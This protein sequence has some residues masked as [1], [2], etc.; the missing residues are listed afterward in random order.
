MKKVSLV[1]IILMASF[2]SFAQQK[3][4]GTKT[5]GQW[6]FEK[7]PLQYSVTPAKTLYYKNSRTGRLEYYQEFNQ[8]GQ[9]N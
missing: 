6:T 1:L 5:I 9:I 7:F 8:L 3:N 4:F 2:A